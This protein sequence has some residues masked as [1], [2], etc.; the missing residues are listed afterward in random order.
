VKH[1][2]DDKKDANDSV[3]QRENINILGERVISVCASGLG[4]VLYGKKADE[5]YA[6]HADD[7]ESIQQKAIEAC[8]ERL[9]YYGVKLRTVELLPATRIG[10]EVLAQSIKDAGPKSPIE[11]AVIAS[12]QAPGADGRGEIIPFPSP[13]D[14]A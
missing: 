8:E 10:E 5:L 1:E 13:S 12:R 4:R 3:L 9:I 14:A 6:I 11:A 2:K 7:P